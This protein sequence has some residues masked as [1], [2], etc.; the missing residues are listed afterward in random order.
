[1]L[2]VLILLCTYWHLSFNLDSEINWLL[3]YFLFVILF[4]MC[5]SLLLY[6]NYAYWRGHI[7]KQTF[8]FETKYLSKCLS[9]LFKINLSQTIY[10]NFEFYL[11]SLYS[12]S[13]LIM[14][15]FFCTTI[16]NIKIVVH[17]KFLNFKKLQAKRI[18]D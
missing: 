7:L 6:Y 1:M 17:F 11:F 13:Q 9:F 4:R 15:G 14:W 12:N 18:L 16:L 2:W 3:C 8:H 10:F 5:L